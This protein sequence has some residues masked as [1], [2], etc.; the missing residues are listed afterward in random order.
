MGRSGADGAPHADNLV[1]GNGKPPYPEA[2][3][4]AWVLQGHKE[5]T[6]RFRI[7]ASVLRWAALPP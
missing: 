7:D 4:A 3:M 5:E 6:A 1:M 2:G